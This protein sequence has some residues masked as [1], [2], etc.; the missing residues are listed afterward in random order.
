MSIY[1]RIDERRTNISWSVMHDPQDRHTE[2]SPFSPADWIEMIEVWPATL[3]QC[4]RQWAWL[5]STKSFPGHLLYRQEAYRVG[6]RQGTY[7]SFSRNRAHTVQY[8]PY[9]CTN[10]LQWLQI[11]FQFLYFSVLEGRF[12]LPASLKPML[13]LCTRMFLYVKNCNSVLQ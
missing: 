11:F 2:T 1:P 12:S 3:R 9:I 10:G 7:H 5:G 13:P 6:S 8:L 4:S